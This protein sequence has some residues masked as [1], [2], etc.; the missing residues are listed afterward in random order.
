MLLMDNFVRQI[1]ERGPLQR[2][3]TD[4]RSSSPLN[5]LENRK[6]FSM[7]DDIQVPCHLRSDDGVR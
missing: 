1:G 3:S 6:L 5:G 7:L 2:R 4:E